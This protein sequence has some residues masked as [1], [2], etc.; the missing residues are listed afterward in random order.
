MLSKYK[1]TKKF[2][3]LLIGFMSIGLFFAPISMALND[4]G[5]GGGSATE[6]A[7]DC[8]EIADSADKAECQQK[9]RSCNTLS[10]DDKAACQKNI[11]SQYRGAEII[12]ASGSPVSG[13]T[14]GDSGSTGSR[15]SIQ[16]DCNYDDSNELD[17]GCKIFSYLIDLINILTALVGVVV[18]IMIVIGGIQYSAARDNPQAIQAAKGKI[19][20]AVLAL[21]VFI[22]TSAFLQWIVP[23]GV[24]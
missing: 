1:I 24:L 15:S 9:I 8:S 10:A 13:P 12:D 21:V 4:T 20:N 22:F 11:A 23:G 6:V 7:E 14:S 17:G 3:A 5:G 2:T 18:V 16:S 19:T